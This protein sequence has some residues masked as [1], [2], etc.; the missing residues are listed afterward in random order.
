MT[1]EEEFEKQIKAA[2]DLEQLAK[3]LQELLSGGYSVWHDGRLYRIKVLVEQFRDLKIV[4]RPN[5]HPP[6]H[7]H[8]LCQNFNASFI[9]ESGELL[10]GR[11]DPIH[12][13]LVRVW[14]KDA[15]PLLNKKWAET[16]PGS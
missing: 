1:L 5:D 3:P 15:I 12:H 7:F 8:A 9:I 2:T 14:H 6:P 13:R 10:E 4:I 11:I 16:R